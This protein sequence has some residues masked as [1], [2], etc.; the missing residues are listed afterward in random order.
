MFTRTAA[1]ELGQYGIRVNAVSLGVVSREGIEKSWP[2]GVNLG[3]KMWQVLNT[4]E[5]L[6]R[7]GLYVG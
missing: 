7:P 4:V 2:D 3:C 6:M 1:R 5:K